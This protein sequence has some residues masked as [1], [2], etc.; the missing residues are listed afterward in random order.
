[1][2]TPVATRVY[3]PSTPGRLRAVLA[4]G[5]IG[6]APFVAHAVTDAV[7]EALADLGEEEWEHAAATIAAQ[8]SVV[9]LTDDE[10]ARRVVLALDVPA[11]R[12]PARAGDPGDPTQVEVAEEAPL[13]RL[14]A[15]L[16]DSRDAEEVVAA[17]RDAVARRAP[18]A[19]G[20]LERCL[21][22]EPGWWAV[23]E[24]DVLLEDVDG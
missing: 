16:A 23:Q 6:P 8:S 15:V 9:L 7:R 21:E 4:A 24:L 14:A 2:S 20:L 13:R 10:P 3:V 12:A 18:E 19:D 5:R 11:V 17:A 1:V 22:A